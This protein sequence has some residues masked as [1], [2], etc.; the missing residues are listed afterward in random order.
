[1]QMKAKRAGNSLK[2]LAIDLLLD[3]DCSPEGLS[4]VELLHEGGYVFFLGRLLKHFGVEPRCAIHLGGNTGQESIP[5]MMMGFEKVLYVEAHPDTCVQL[6]RNLAKL[7]LLE[8][9]V[10]TYLHTK[11]ITQFTAVQAAVGDRNGETTLY[12][13]GSSL[14]HSTRKPVGFDEW[15]EWVLERSTEQEAAEF[16]AWAKEGLVLKSEIK[17]P[18]RTLDTIM[19][20]DLPAGWKAE[21]FNVLGMNIQGAEMDALRGAE[22]SLRH[23]ELIQTE[24]N[25][26]EHYQGNPTADELQAFLES[27]GFQLVST[28]RAGPVGTGVYV[29][30]KRS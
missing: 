17:V 15:Q 1:M 14:F 23:V 25:Y 18:M 10:A 22:R 19:E 27:A 6:R 5:Y 28:V 21:D 3:A 9:E 2:G 30:R 20:Q 26:V 16:K 24:L 7:N 13:C 4:R 11:P 29:R 8:N 12:E